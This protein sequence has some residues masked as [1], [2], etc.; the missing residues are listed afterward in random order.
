MSVYLI[1]M[2]LACVIFGLL[3]FER[4]GATGTF[5]GI[6]FVVGL[7]SLSIAVELWVRRIIRA[8]E[9]SRK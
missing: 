8:I 5:W 9:R 4:S 1:P 7:Y 3:N 2:G 6:M